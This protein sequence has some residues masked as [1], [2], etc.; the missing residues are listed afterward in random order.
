MLIIIMDSIIA[1][2]FDIEK[3]LIEEK[4]KNKKNKNEPPLIQFINSNVV[5][6]FD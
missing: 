2:V 6:S 3:D 1:D 4:L 5:I